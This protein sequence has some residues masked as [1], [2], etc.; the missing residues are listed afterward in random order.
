MSSCAKV[1]L[2][3]NHRLDWLEKAHL[4]IITIVFQFVTT[5]Q[6][7]NYAFFRSFLIC[8]ALSENPTKDPT[9][10]GKRQ[11]VSG[12]G[13]GSMVHGSRATRKLTNWQI[14]LDRSDRFIVVRLQV[15]RVKETE[16][17]TVTDAHELGYDR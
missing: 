13:S 9:N 17:P 11:M 10:R 4:A 3:A 12:Q 16:A 5:S 7:F 1:N 15:V 8:E 2:R 14:V 6:A